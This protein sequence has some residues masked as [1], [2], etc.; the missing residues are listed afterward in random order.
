MIREEKKAPW[1]I[2]K[3]G[4][5][6]CQLLKSFSSRQPPYPDDPATPISH[7]ITALLQMKF[8]LDHFPRVMRVCPANSGVFATAELKDTLCA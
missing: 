1:C 7:K 4:N 3:H 2:R 8:A 5:T 6:L